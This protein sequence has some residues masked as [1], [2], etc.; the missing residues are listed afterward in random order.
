MGALWGK[1]TTEQMAEVVK[2][3]Q[4]RRR[5][6]ERAAENL[7]MDRVMLELEYEDAINK[8]QRETALV[9]AQMIFRKQQQVRGQNSCCLLFHF[10]LSPIQVNTENRNASVFTM[11]ETAA[12]SAAS[13]VQLDGIMV[14]LEAALDSAN[15]GISLK[16]I[17]NALVGIGKGMQVLKAKSTVLLLLRCTPTVANNSCS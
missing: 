12:R 17:E 2:D 4:R 8:G 5:E 11:A 14:T 9:K 6:H 10:C 15:R 16:R 13:Q 3:C 7:E 1:T